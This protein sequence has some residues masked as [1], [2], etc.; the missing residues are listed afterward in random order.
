MAIEQEGGGDLGGNWLEARS[1]SN[2][3]HC[4]RSKSDLT[5]RWILTA[6]LPSS[7]VYIWKTIFLDELTSL[8]A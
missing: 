7:C 2:M 4:Y 8:R 1:W 5:N 3:F 6:P